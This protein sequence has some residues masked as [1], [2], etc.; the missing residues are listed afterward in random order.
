MNDIQKGDN[1]KK[2]FIK[3]R[4]NASLLNASNKK[5]MN[6]LLEQKELEKGENGT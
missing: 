1:F 5:R 4:Q 2:K 6:L 3:F